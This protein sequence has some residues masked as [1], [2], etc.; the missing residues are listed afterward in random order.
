MFFIQREKDFKLICFVLGPC[1]ASYFSSSFSSLFLSAT[2]G[3]EDGSQDNGREEFDYMTREGHLSAWKKRTTH[4]AHASVS[5]VRSLYELY[6][7]VKY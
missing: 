2:Q 5:P 7:F 3:T 4:T 1:G 6:M